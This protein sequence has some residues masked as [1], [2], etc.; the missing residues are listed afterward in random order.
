[1][2]RAVRPCVV[3]PAFFLVGVL[4]LAGPPGA[5][6]LTRQLARYDGPPPSPFGLSTDC[7]LQDWNMC[8]GWIWIFDDAEGAVW[9]HVFDPRECPGGCPEGGHITEIRLFS[10]CR[11]VPGSMNGIGVAAVDALGCRTAILY[12]GPPFTI[13][14]CVS[15][16]GWTTIPV[17]DVYV[18]GAPFAV[19]VTW[20]PQSAGLSNARLAS[21]NGIANLACRDD[22]FYV[23]PGCASSVSDCTGWVMP[24]QRSFAYISD[25]NG[26]GQL[27]DLCALYGEPGSLAFPYYYPYG[28]YGLLTNNLL[29]SVRLDCSTPSA[30]EP[31]SW[32][33][34]KRLFE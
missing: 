31:M 12:Q 34:V 19:T 33:R 2:R 21:D 7:M 17:P 28:P 1:M 6:A 25:V 14:H 5:R 27:D 4:A 32:G 26:D 16:D 10:R 3:V 29:M 18:A 11:A 24:P 30:V 9:G 23:F 8:A 15:G 13:T 22:W 20:G